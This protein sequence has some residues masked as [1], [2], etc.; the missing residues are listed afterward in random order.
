MHPTDRQLHI[1]SLCARGYSREDIGREL[2]ISPWTVK[3]DLDR[4]RTKVG[5]CN[6]THALAICIGAGLLIVVGNL[7]SVPS[8]ELELVAA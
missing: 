6:V 7:V 8:D 2:F 1:L 4:L 3:V 5:A